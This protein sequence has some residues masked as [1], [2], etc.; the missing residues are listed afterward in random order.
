MVEGFLDVIGSTRLDCPLGIFFFSLGADNYH[1]NV[2]EPRFELHL[3][4]EFQAVHVG[5]VDVEKDDVDVRIARQDFET[6]SPIVGMHH[7]VLAQ[8]HVEHLVDE[9]GIV[10]D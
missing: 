4:E 8:H 1:R 9:L 3:V 2:R 10:D 5:H 6:F 7:L